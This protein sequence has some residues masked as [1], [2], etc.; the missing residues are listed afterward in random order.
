ME[1]KNGEF[2]GKA[3][4]SSLSERASSKREKKRPESVRERKK[5]FYLASNAGTNVFSV[6]LCIVSRGRFGFFSLLCLL[7]WVSIT[8]NVILEHGTSNRF[9]SA[10]NFRRI[11]REP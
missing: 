2:A 8:V 9:R 11:F 1:W 7:F 6:K 10:W 3:Q 5:P 4:L